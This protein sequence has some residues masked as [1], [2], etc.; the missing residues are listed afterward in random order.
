MH[1]VEELL[2]PKEEPRDVEQQQAEVQRLEA[3]THVEPSTRDGRKRTREAERLLLAARD[4][5]GEPTSQRKKRR[6]P[7]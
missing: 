4:N 6:S 5:V 3:H 2:D 1:A 7:E